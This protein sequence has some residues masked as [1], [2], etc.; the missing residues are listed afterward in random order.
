MWVWLPVFVKKLANNT[1][2]TTLID[3]TLLCLFVYAAEPMNDNI[4]KIGG[5]YLYW[6]LKIVNER[7]IRIV[8]FF[9][10]LLELIRNINDHRTGCW[11]VRR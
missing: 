5:R 11:R 8:F 10:L 3:A 2:R 4:K 1:M 6:Y 9:L 7:V